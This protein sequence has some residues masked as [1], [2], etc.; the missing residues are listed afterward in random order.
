MTSVAPPSP[1]VCRAKRGRLSADLD[2]CSPHGKRSR[3]VS[4]LD[5]CGGSV[6]FGAVR[7]RLQ[8]LFPDMDEKVRMQ[9]PSRPQSPGESKRSVFV[10]PVSQLA[11]LAQRVYATGPGAMHHTLLHV[12]HAQVITRVLDTCHGD[13]DEALEKLTELSLTTNSSPTAEQAGAFS[14]KLVQR[15]R[16]LAMATGLATFRS[17]RNGAR[18]VI[19]F[20]HTVTSLVRCLDLSV[21]KK[22][23]LCRKSAS[24]NTAAAAAAV[25]NRTSGATAHR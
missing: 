20:L 13:F 8:T 6:R 19:I 15:Q 1:Q 18:S 11:V 7:C 16:P 17:A 5:Q 24:T 25:P 4:G 12:L 14:H 10:A 22:Y 2:Y 3:Y 23:I 21:T 9:R